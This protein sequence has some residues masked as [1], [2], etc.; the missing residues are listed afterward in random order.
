LNGRRVLVL[1]RVSGR[2]VFVAGFERAR[3]VFR[4]VLLL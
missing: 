1:L 4:R 2:V 3:R